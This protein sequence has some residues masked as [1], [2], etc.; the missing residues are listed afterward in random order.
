M[1]EKRFDTKGWSPEPALEVSW[2][3]G[4]AAVLMLLAIAGGF[5][6]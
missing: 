5:V 2:D 3:F 6:R 1:K 4:L